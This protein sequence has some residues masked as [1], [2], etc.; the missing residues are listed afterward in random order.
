MS[1]S[2]PEGGSEDGSRHVAYMATALL[3]LQWSVRPLYLFHA[4]ETLL[5]GAGAVGR[6][7][8]GRSERKVGKRE[9]G[10]GNQ[11]INGN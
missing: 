6:Y 1:Y 8:R 9:Q 5:S 3:K 11:P 10:G 7:V 4:G 2:A